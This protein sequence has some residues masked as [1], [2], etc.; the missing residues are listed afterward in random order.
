[1][2]KDTATTTTKLYSE[3]QHWFI[4]S[5]AC[6]FPTQCHYTV[7]QLHHIKKKHAL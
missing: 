2:Q 4:I 1:M 6:Q 7:S 5:T 3:W